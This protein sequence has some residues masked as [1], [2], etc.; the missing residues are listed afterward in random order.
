MGQSQSSDRQKKWFSLKTFLVNGINRYFNILII[1]S[2]INS[3]KD[4][5]KINNLL[6]LI[7]SQGFKIY[8]NLKQ[9][10]N[11]TY[12]LVIKWLNEYLYTGKI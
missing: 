10:Q 12:D 5:R 2:S 8:N 1:T 11:I 3:E 9:P 7:R 4:N 6:N